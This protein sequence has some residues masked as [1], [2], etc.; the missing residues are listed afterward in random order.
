M[1]ISTLL[2][3]NV[4]DG[5]I[6]SFLV[7]LSVQRDPDRK[8]ARRFFSDDANGAYGLTPRPLSDGLKAFLSQGLVT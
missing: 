4:A 8:A 7:G 5:A 1:K 3:L 2:A 6:G